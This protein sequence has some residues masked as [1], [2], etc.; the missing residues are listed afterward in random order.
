MKFAKVWQMSSLF[1]HR[2][3]LKT[4]NKLYVDSL[5]IAC[6]ERFGDTPLHIIN[7]S[8]SDIRL[9]PKSFRPV[10]AHC[11]NANQCHALC[12]RL[13]QIDPGGD[14]VLFAS[15]LEVSSLKMHAIIE[16]RFG[17]TP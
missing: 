12:I 15:D 8:L 7:S 13:T 3:Y 1:S 10:D 14:S 5:S 16:K 4:A 6:V 17:K 2:V 9:I 11:P